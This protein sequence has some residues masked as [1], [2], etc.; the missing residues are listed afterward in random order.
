[1]IINK[2]YDERFTPHGDY[3]K[4]Q[5]G[6]Y[7]EPR[8]VAL[9][10]KQVYETVQKK[11]S[12]VFKAKIELPDEMIFRIVE[13]LQDVSLRTTDL[14]AKGRAFENFLGKLFRGE[15]GQYFTARQVVEFMVGVA[16]PDEF[17]YLIDPAC[18]SGGFLLY[19]MKHV[20]TK[21]TDKYKAIK[22]QLI[23]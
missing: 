18:G 6:T 13:H 23:G 22:K 2:L 9:R 8:E 21:V 5:I 14:D 12:D 15:Y 16:D 10:I 3:Y 1:L 17:D 11:N 19:A 7:E 20:L 4:F